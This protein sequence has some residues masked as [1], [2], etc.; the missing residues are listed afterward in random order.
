MR[1]G[2]AT[3]KDET[4]TMAAVPA[5][6]TEAT[7]EPP[8]LLVRAQ[9][10]RRETQ[11]SANLVPRAP[12][13]KSPATQHAVRARLTLA[14]RPRALIRL[15]R[16]NVNRAGKGATATRPQVVTPIHANIMDIAPREVGRTPAN[17]RTATAAR[18]VKQI[19][20]PK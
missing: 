19:R 11:A 8:V 2:K 15:Q 12:G 9:Q 20:V 14:R 16:A 10:V 18:A 4:V 6:A 13:K 7:V 1:D 3:F 5:V 17:V